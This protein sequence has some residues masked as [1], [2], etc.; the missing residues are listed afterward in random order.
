MCDKKFEDHKIEMRK[1]G[2][3]LIPYNF[4]QSP[5]GDEDDLNHLKARE[6][7]I[8][9]YNLILHYSKA[10]YRT[11]KLE[12]LQILGKYSPFLPFSLVCKI[13]KKFLG[14]QYLSLVELFK[15]NRK[16]YCWNL[17]LNRHGIPIPG[18]LGGDD[19]DTG[20]ECTYEGLQ[21]RSVSPRQVN[22]H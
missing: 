17:L 1:L 7:Y 3:F 22:F 19:D 4:P 18:S 21:Y 20:E 8:D 10:D 9:G 16:I 11:Y 2:E 6:V 15:D 5:P 13:G 14:E 12:T